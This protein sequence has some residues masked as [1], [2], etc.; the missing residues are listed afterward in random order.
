MIQPTLD[1]ELIKF[2]REMLLTMHNPADSL[3]KL[4]YDISD[5]PI[6]EPSRTTIK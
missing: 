5:I 3:L 4:I 1:T 2:K 6:I